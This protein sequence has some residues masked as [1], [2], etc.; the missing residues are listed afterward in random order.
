MLS[1]GVGL[2]LFVAVAIA[3]SL[4][5]ARRALRIDPSSALRYE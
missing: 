5:P 3:G 1:F 2:L 4:A